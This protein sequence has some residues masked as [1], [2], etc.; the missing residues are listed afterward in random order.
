MFKIE[1]F[2]ANSTE[3]ENHPIEVVEEEHEMNVSQ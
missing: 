1:F 2:S 3:N